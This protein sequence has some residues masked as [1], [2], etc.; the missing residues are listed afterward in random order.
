MNDIGASRNDTVN[1][2]QTESRTAKKPG[3]IRH[4]RV[5]KV[6]FFVM[7]TL[8]VVELVVY[9]IVLPGLGSPNIKFVGVKNHSDT[10]LMQIIAPF[11][12]DSWFLFDAVK[13]EDALASS[14]AIAYATATKY[15]PN[16]VVI[17]ITER[18]PVAMTFL[19]S[20]GR[21]IPVEID[22]NG[23]LFEQRTASYDAIPIV[24]G[25][26]VENLS[27]GMRIPSK[28]R[29]LIEQIAHIRSLP[30]HYFAALSEICVV[31]KEYGNYELVLI[32]AYSKIKVLTDRALNEGALQYMMV[33]L[34]VVGSIEPNVSEVDLRY[35]S[36]SYRTR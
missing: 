24:S 23:I 4:I 31:P 33:V 8:L 26:P 27:S 10:E 14:P 36:V 19:N 29:T 7:L 34:D 5:V 16:N 9:K 20:G 2:N 35:G 28:Y 13:V 12:N 1:I 25:L 30:Q 18:E 22:K 17:S 6:V 3:V 11:T 15:F 21:S 32:P